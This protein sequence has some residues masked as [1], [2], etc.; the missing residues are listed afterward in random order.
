MDKTPLNSIFIEFSQFAGE[1]AES[2]S[3]NRSIGQIYGLLYLYT[4]PMSL[5]DISQS[6]KMSKGNA[7]VNLR[8]LESWGAVKSVW[9]S[10]S[11]Q[12]YYEVSRD[13][14]DLLVHRV[15]EGLSRRLE[16]AEEKLQHLVT[17]TSH[18][19]K[20]QE[21]MNE[22]FS[23]IVRGKKITHMLSSHSALLRKVFS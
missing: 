6:L 23:L 5:K 8:I 3:F 14:K 7:S 13:I 20:T 2:L 9:V 12:D 17:K 16:I 10:G 22:I 4:K 21:K 11:R 18:S 19:Q 1:M 15:Q